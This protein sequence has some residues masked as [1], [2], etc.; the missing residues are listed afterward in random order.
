MNLVGYLK[1]TVAELKAVRWPTREETIRLT[2][3]VIGISIFVGAYVGLLDI[4]F[5]KALSE[6]LK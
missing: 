2:T 3:I 1:D 5:T 4:T 6:I